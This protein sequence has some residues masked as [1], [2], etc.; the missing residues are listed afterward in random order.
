MCTK[1]R[2]PRTTFNIGLIVLTYI[3]SI[4]IKTFFCTNKQNKTIV[5]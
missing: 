4:P 5:N 3:K 2:N 1:I